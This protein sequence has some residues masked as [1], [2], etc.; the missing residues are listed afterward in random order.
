MDD[1]RLNEIKYKVKEWM[2]GDDLSFIFDQIKQ[3]LAMEMANTLPEEVDKRNEKYQL[4]R[5]IKALEQQF[6]SYVNDI[7]SIEENK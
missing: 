2:E 1:Y 6:R 5:G 3:R 7:V 4:I